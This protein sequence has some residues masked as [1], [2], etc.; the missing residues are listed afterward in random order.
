MS[1]EDLSEL[2]N[3][4]L[5]AEENLRDDLTEDVLQQESWDLVLSRDYG[6]EVF[7]AMDVVARL[8]LFRRVMDA[9]NFQEV[10]EGQHYLLKGLFIT[11]NSIH[12]FNAWIHS[13]KRNGRLNPLRL[14]IAFAFLIKTI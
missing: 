7:K 3:T 4:A 6:G 2:G 12:G 13:L 5:V 8:Q 1:S 10:H 14:L 9:I 11:L